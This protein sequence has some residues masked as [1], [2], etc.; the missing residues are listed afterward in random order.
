[1]TEACLPLV[2]HGWIPP[3][4]KL[5]VKM[6][7]RVGEGIGKAGNK[8]I[9]APV[10]LEVNDSQ[11]GLGKAAQYDAII[12]ETATESIDRRR[13]LEEDADVTERKRQELERRAEIEVNLKEELKEFYC[14]ICC[15]QY[16]SVA[17]WHTHLQSW[18]HVHTRNMR[19]LREKD[20][21][22]RNATAGSA[23]DKRRK[24]ARREVRM[25]R[26]IIIFFF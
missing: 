3:R 19:E 8:G 1:M 20:A 22:R 13:R 11:L 14:D 25:S 6:G 24:E 10:E 15:K 2:M 23:Q 17:E 21:Q 18:G 7:W 5:L 16:K 4:F 26:I 9:T 12:S